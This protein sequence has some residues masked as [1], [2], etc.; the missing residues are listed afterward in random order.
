MGQRLRRFPP[1][2][3][4]RASRVDAVKKRFAKMQLVRKVFSR[5][6][7]G[8]RVYKNPVTEEG[9]EIKD[10]EPSGKKQAYYLESDP[11]LRRKRGKKKFMR[12]SATSSL[13]RPVK[14]ESDDASVE[15]ILSDDS[16]SSVDTQV[17]R[18]RSSGVVRTSMYVL[19]GVAGDETMRKDRHHAR[20]EKIK[21]KFTGGKS[22]F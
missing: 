9:E 8:G 11:D 7:G 20:I 1:T 19:S 15:D 14:R 5:N 22:V 10:L 17:E 12:D 3:F 6:E 2:D 13:D 21:H 16:P 18:A 4:E